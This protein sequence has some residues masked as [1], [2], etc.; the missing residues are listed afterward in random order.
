MKKFLLLFFFSASVAAVSAQHR[1]SYGVKAGINVSQIYNKFAQD[2][3]DLRCA[4]VAGAFVGYRFA[5]GRLGVQ[6]EVLYSGRGGRYGSRARAYDY[7]DVPLL[8]KVKLWK[9]LD[10][11]AGGQ[12]GYLF[13]AQEKMKNSK[14]QAITDAR[15]HEF[16]AVGGLSYD[17][18]EHL[19]VDGRVVIGTM[20]LQ[21]IDVKNSKKLYSSTAALTL[22][23][24]F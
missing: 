10:L 8:L 18:T 14:P 13:N 20:R 7:I 22:G 6:A 5:D 23:L 4:P 24:R 11:N 12:Y 17:I 19:F 21:D 1:V 15:R 9:G 3:S 16:S 2:G